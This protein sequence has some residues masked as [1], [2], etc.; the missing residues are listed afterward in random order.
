[1]PAAYGGSQ[2]R[3]QIAATAAGLRHVHSNSGAGLHLLPSPQL[4]AM[5]DPYPLSE[6][7]D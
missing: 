6:P 1:M 7:R 2:P 4:M 5:L 3:G